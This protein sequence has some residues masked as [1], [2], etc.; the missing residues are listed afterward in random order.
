MKIGIIGTGYVG[1]VTGTCFADSGNDVI[2]VDVDQE[3]VER[4]RNGE[5]P[6]YEPGL[7]RVFDRAIRDKRL[8]FTTDLEKAFKESDIIFLCLPTPPD[9]EEHTSELQSRGHLVCRLLL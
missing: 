8:E 4:M 9:S 7:N 5:V 2:C 6:I 3:K 1:L